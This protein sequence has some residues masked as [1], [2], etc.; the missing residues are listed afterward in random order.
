MVQ[1]QCRRW[2]FT[3]NNWTQ[4]EFDLLI[5]PDNFPSKFSYLLFGREIAP[6]TGTPHLQG[7]F[8]VPK[9]RGRLGLGASL[10]G[11]S[12]GSFLFYFCFDV[13][14]LIALSESASRMLE[15]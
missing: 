7:Y 8:E 4:A 13:L 5:Q 12:R 10:P 3:L 11:L 15:G 2:V 1:L 9:K 6:K 14:V